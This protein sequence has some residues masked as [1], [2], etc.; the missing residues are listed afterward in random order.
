MTL[1]HA[2]VVLDIG[3]S[4]TTYP[5]GRIAGEDAHQL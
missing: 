1:I 3:S 2:A 4:T 5:T